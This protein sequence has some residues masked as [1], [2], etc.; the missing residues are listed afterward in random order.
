M[1]LG[2]YSTLKSNNSYYQCQL[3]GS[4]ELKS[5]H[6][7]STYWPKLEMCMRFND[8]SLPSDIEFLSDEPVLGRNIHLGINIFMD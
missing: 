3:D 2:K 7:K 5:C 8:E 6:G 4:A 1:K